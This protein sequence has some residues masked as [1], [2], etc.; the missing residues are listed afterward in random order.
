[1]AEVTNTWCL[2]CF[3]VEWSRAGC[4]CLVWMNIPTQESLRLGLQVPF[5]YL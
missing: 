5:F 1:M 4:V 2:F 3:L